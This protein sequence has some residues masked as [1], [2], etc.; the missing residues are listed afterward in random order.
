M[1]KVRTGHLSATE[2]EREAASW[3]HRRTGQA[4]RGV[5][6]TVRRYVVGPATVQITFRKREVTPAD[7]LHV[8]DRVRSMVEGGSA[9]DVSNGTVAG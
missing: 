8:L 6:S 5:R 4:A 9:G 2:T 7:V 1:E 3:K